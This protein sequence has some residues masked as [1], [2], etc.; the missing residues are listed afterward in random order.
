MGSCSKEQKSLPAFLLAVSLYCL[1]FN[2]LHL[3]KAPGLTGLFSHRLLLLFLVNILFGNG[4][5]HTD[6]ICG[7]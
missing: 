5:D 4:T 1:T 7:L 6:L 2:A 3:E